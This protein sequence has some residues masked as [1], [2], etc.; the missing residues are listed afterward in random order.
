MKQ[1]GDYVLAVN[2]PMFRRHII[3]DET[4]VAGRT[5][6]EELSRLP[7]GQYLVGLK[8]WFEGT[9]EQDGNGSDKVSVPCYA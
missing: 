9:Y 6:T 2:R 3:M 5:V 4:W 7:A 8:F 1:Q